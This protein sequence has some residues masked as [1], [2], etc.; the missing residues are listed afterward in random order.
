MEL[1]D[2]KSFKFKTKVV[3]DKIFEVFKGHFSSIPVL[4]K[5][6]K[7]K[8]ASDKLIDSTIRFHFAYHV[9]LVWLSD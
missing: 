2:T 7:S 9:K 6:T 8:F 3:K 1:N 4:Y 5:L